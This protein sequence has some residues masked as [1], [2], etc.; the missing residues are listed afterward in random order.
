MP[1][2][3][4]GMETGKVDPYDVLLFTDSGSARVY[5]SFGK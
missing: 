1:Q 4:P 5:R 3:A 2:G